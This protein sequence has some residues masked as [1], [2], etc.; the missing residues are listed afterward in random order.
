[1]VKL[2][3]NIVYLNALK[4]REGKITPKILP[5]PLS[6]LK[7]TFILN[8][9]ILIQLRSKKNPAIFNQKD[10][11]NINPAG[12]LSPFFSSR[13]WRNSSKIVINGKKVIMHF[14]FSMISYQSDGCKIP[15]LINAYE[16]GTC[17]I[18]GEISPAL[19]S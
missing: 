6:D 10:C 8:Q 5:S 11:R 12:I 4:R 15:A 1:M 19:S 13:F 2:I 9:F 16:Q 17:N 14:L 7:G 18:A 3:I